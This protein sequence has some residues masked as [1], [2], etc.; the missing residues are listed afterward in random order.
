M[1]E[2]YIS[3]IAFESKLKQMW[4][5]LISKSVLI[6]RHY[7]ISVYILF[8]SIYNLDQWLQINLLVISPCMSL[9]RSMYREL[10]LELVSLV[11][12]EARDPFKMLHEEALTRQR[13]EK[14][15]NFA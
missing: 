2:G 11:D 12:D 10:G 9:T 6:E 3:R 5:G 13:N 1:V 7:S 15:H 8:H 14:M 4:Y